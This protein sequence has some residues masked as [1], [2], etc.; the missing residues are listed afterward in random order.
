MNTSKEF[1]YFIRHPSF[2]SFA[3]IRTEK[4][5]PT[6]PPVGFQ[7]LMP[8]NRGCVHEGVLIQQDKQRLDELK[9]DLPEWFRD[10]E[11]RAFKSMGEIPYQ[12][13]VHHIAM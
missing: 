3:L 6:E 13:V 10:I 7:E 12:L 8:G 4:E 11:K 5:L 1:F 2:D 9:R